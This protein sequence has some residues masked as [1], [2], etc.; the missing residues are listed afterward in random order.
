MSIIAEVFLINQTEC[1]ECWKLQAKSICKFGS[2]ALCLIIYKTVKLWL[3]ASLVALYYLPCS[4]TATIM[5]HA[6]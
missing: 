3:L 1:F 4:R 5:K 6:E 2:F